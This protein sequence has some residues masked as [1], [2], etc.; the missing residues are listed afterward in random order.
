[1]LKACPCLRFRIR[2]IPGLG[3]E[4]QKNGIT[5][6]FGE[7]LRA[8]KKFAKDER[9]EHTD[10]T[11]IEQLLNVFAAAAEG[12]PEVQQEPGK[13]GDR[14]APDFKVTKSG[15][16]LGYIETK[17]VGVN[18]AKVLKSD[19]MKRYQA[20]SDNILLTDYLEWIWIRKGSKQTEA[21][22]HETDLENPKFRLRD[23]LGEE[24][25]RQEREH[26]QGRLYGLY[27]TFRDQ[28]VSRTQA[29]GIRRCLRAD[30]GLGATCRATVSPPPTRGGRNAEA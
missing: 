10:R 27:K 26:Q 15:M 9:R 13:I 1:V 25:V 6:A 30:A 19:Q 21:L 17:A 2:T 3:L 14:G 7:Y 16:I 8:L 22:C 5:E 12:R 23:A 11:A 29:E 24:L 18:L 28:G 4:Q 20:L